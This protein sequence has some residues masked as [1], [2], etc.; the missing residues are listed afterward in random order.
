MRSQVYF[1]CI[2]IGVFSVETPTDECPRYD[3]STRVHKEEHGPD[4]VEDTDDEDGHDEG[5]NFEVLVGQ[6]VGLFHWGCDRVEGERE[7]EPQEEEE[8]G[9]SCQ[10]DG[11]DDYGVVIPEELVTPID[12]IHCLPDLIPV[13]HEEEEKNNGQ[14]VANHRNT[15]SKGLILLKNEGLFAN[16]IHGQVEIHSETNQRQDDEDVEEVNDVPRHHSDQ[17][18]C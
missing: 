4:E 17:N 15:N 10:D 18:Q 1:G 5:W 8:D 9:A 12:V 2:Q 11:E 13:R 14:Q 6:L 16:L 3:A 7:E